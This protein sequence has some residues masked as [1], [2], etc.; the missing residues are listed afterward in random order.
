MS[1]CFNLVKI[2]V[3]A[4]PEGSPSS[5]LAAMSATPPAG[6][7]SLKLARSNR[8]SPARKRAD[9]VGDMT[10]RLICAG[11]AVL[12]AVVLLLIVKEVVEGAQPAI[13]KFG[14]G[15]ITNQEWAPPLEKFGGRGPDLRHPDHLGDG[16]GDRRPGGD[17][18]RHLPGAAG[19]GL[20]PQR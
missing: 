11:A 7:A 15:F 3:V 12:A 5:T 14:L 6:T 10:L 17:L 20:G 18:D 9:R 16:P 1:S 8:Q 4:L 2:G 13:S 19:A